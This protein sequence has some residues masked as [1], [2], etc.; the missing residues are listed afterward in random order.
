MA[1]SLNMGVSKNK[2]HHRTDPRFAPYLERQKKRDLVHE[3]VI[4]KI[5]T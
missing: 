4:I 2:L 3:C 1:D 5:E